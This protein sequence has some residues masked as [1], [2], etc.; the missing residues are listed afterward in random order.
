VRKVSHQH[1]TMTKEGSEHAYFL[2]FSGERRAVISSTF[3]TRS[4]VGLEDGEDDFLK[5]AL[6]SNCHPHRVEFCGGCLFSES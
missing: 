2:A 1:K 3:F 6:T 4:N 5:T